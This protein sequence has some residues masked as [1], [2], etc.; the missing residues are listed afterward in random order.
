MTFDT[1]FNKQDTLIKVILLILPLVG[2][3]VECLVRLSVALRTKSVVNIVVFVV[4]LVIG[5]GWFL[6]LLDLIYM[7]VTG[8]LFLAE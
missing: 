5:W 1:W 3:V 6:G 8:H 7:I 4:F 2:W